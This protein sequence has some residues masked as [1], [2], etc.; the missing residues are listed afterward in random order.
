MC[1]YFALQGGVMFL[2][3]LKTRWYDCYTNAHVQTG[4]FGERRSRYLP[5]SSCY[6]PSGSIRFSS[7]VSDGTLL[8]MV[9]AAVV[10]F[11]VLVCPQRLDVKFGLPTTAASTGPVWMW[12]CVHARYNIEN[13]LPSTAF[14]LLIAQLL[15]F[16]IMTTT[17]WENLIHQDLLDLGELW[18]PKGRESGRG[19][20]INYRVLVHS[21]KGNTNSNKYIE[22]H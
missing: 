14:E 13:N 4:D 11:C 10:S 20:E 7:S 15:I 21:N 1:P 2:A 12:G 9:V 5:W 6:H 19:M 3:A 22:N 8:A 16:A 18:I 17:L